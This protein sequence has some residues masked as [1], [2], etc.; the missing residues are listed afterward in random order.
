[1]YPCWI[2]QHDPYWA[3]LG[4]CD[5]EG[6]RTQRNRQGTEKT[7]KEKV[8]KNNEV[9][10]GTGWTKMVDSGRRGR[11]GE[12][13]GEVQAGCTQMVDP[14]KRKKGGES[15]RQ[16]D[17]PKWSTL[18]G[19]QVLGPGNEMC[20]NHSRKTRTF[21]TRRLEP[22][23]PHGQCAQQDFLSLKVQTWLN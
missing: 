11:E 8:R 2:R 14:Y 23:S 21:F 9:R 1:M 18:P 12:E 16:E 7:K 13:G 20:E 4:E 17:G 5:K 19:R 3:T 22:R 15:F 6:E 10:E